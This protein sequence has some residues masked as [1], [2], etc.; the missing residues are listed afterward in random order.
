MN[1]RFAIRFIIAF[2]LLAVVCGGLIGFN[3]FRDRAIQEF[4]ANMPVPPQTVST[5]TAEAM[6][7]TPAI[8]TIGTVKAVPRRRPDGARPAA[9]SRASSSRP[10][11]G[12]AGRGPGSSSTTQVEAPTSKP[13]KT[14]TSLDQLSLNRALELR[15]TGVGTTANLDTAQAA[16]TAGGRAG[17]QAARRVLG[18]EA[19]DGRRFGGTIGIPRIEVGQ[20]VTPGTIVATLQDLD[21]MRV[22]FTVP[23]QA[24]RPLEDRTD[25]PLRA[26][27]RR[28]AALQR[29]ASSASIRR[30]TPETRLVSVRGES[31]Q[32]RWPADA[33]AVRPGPGRAAARGRHPCAAADRRGDQPLR[34]LHLCRT[35][36]RTGRRQ[37]PA[38]RRGDEGRPPSR[39]SPELAANQVFVKVGRRNEGKVEIVEGLKA[40][41]QVVTAGQNRL[42]N[43]MPV[44]VD[45]T[46]NPAGGWSDRRPQK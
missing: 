33:R 20:Y 6:R 34:R 14:Q 18:P 2:V 24:S 16:V 46:I 19:A 31:R 27:R 29:Q 39:R 32:P 38:A 9:S 23:E 17:R 22:D 13:Q 15:E 36:G 40:G 1:R 26:R 30:S 12:R 37:Q 41:D 25:G 10:T 45:N 28:P 8:D 3:I 5:T 35:S 43:G 7:W 44:T 21:T 42:F 4:F 11:T